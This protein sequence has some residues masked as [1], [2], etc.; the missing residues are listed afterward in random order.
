MRGDLDS[1]KG[2][3]A[4]GGRCRLPSRRHPRLS[5]REHRAVRH[6]GTGITVRPVRTLEYRIPEYSYTFNSPFPMKG[7]KSRAQR[8]W[9]EMI[10]T[11]S[12]EDQPAWTALTQQKADF[13]ASFPDPETAARAA[14]EA[15]LGPERAEQLD[16]TGEQLTQDE[17][18]RLEAAADQYWLDHFRDWLAQSEMSVDGQRRIIEYLGQA[19]QAALHGT[20]R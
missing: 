2:K 14:I 19:G 13:T 16:R 12:N 6:G 3:V 8:A 18:Q 1:A 10:E 7:L 5:T 20:V 4:F 15:S 17:Q 11:L 9:N